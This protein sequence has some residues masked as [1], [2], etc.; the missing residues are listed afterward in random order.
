ML[1]DR[2]LGSGCKAVGVHRSVIIV[3]LGV[4]MVVGVLVSVDILI[5]GWVYL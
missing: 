1:R 3:V 5:V 2:G 4:L